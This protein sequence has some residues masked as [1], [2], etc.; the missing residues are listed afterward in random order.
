M[1]SMLDFLPTLTGPMCLNRWDDLLHTMHTSNTNSTGPP[2]RQH[3]TR[4]T[5]ALVTLCEV[6]WTYGQFPCAV[7]SHALLSHAV[8]CA[9]V[10]QVLCC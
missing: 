7:P 1:S 9:T 4:N 2:Q 5:Q 10:L 8:L 3:A 6:K